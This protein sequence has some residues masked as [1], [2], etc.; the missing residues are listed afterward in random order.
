MLKFF[1]RLE[2]TRNVVLFAFAILMVGSLVFFYTPSRNTVSANL[3]QSDET[4]ASVAAHPISVGEVVRQKENYAQF[5]RGSAFP[6]RTIL[7][8]IIGSRIIRAEAER[9]G[10]TA[11]D[12][13]VADRLREQNKPTDGK[14][15]DLATYERNVTEQFGS[16]ATYEQSVRDD[17]SGQKLNAFLTSGVTVSEEEVL[18]DFQRKNSKFDV[19][20]VAVNSTELAKAI[21]PTDQELRDYFEKNKQSYYIGVPQKKIKYVF[22]NTSKLGEKLQI[23]DADLKTEYDALPADKKIGG[24]NGQEIVL[25]VAKPDLDSQVLAKATDLVT[26]ARKEGPIVSEETFANLAKGHSE[27]PATAQN[28]GKL[29]GP[30]RENPNKTEDPYQ[31]LLKMKPGEV[32][33]PISYQGRYFILRRGDEVPKTFE[34]AKK[35]IE[36]SLR[37][38]RAYS[39][40]AE[41][42]GKIATSLKETKDPVKT[43]QQFAAE[44]NMSAADMVKETAFVKPG[45][46][47]PNIGI[48]P[49]FEEGINPLGNVGDV[50]D[51][52]PIQNGFAIPMLVDKKEPRD[53]DF[54]EVK[55]QIVD[56]VKLE[57]ARAQ[58][59]E[60][61][62]QIAAR[63]SASA[64][65]AAA[66]AKGLSAKEQKNLILGSPV[67]EGPTA[68]TSE[69]LEDAIF[70]MKV[71]D[72]T[73]TPVKVGD[74]W[75]IVGVTKRE[76]ADTADF[77]KQRS[78]LIE[79]MLGRKRSAVFSDYLTAIKQKYEADGKIKIYKDVLDQIDAVP[80]VPGE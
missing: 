37:N 22:V 44:A 72:V 51:K 63:A 78:G 30:V 29:P 64:L 80:A 38:R 65:G 74:N 23:S 50:G 45:D 55:A 11:S 47:V 9:L 17:L 27:N 21:T 54:E 69:A 41:L 56:V 73:K 42:A 28:G 15:F 79:Q 32:T 8:G 39:V 66:T 10:L 71:G 33:E 77:A 12:K 40:A 1:T 36:V 48:S 7:D 13:E 67:G 70:G 76:D 5:A 16:I 25:R 75:Y 14:P 19:N 62:K 2:K 26:Q 68:G 3:A 35:E 20:Y 6:T 4:V 52:T 24:V 18:K 59:E 58:I 49:Q 57:K 60:V 31:R 43:A 61:A 46:D 53:A 34:Q